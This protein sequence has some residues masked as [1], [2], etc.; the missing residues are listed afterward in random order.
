MNDALVGLL[1][2]LPAV[3]A[4][5]IAF[6]PAKGAALTRSLQF[7]LVLVAALCAYV[8]WQRAGAGMPRFALAWFAFQNLSVEFSLGI[9]GLAR[10]FV[11]LLAATALLVSLAGMRR[12]HDTRPFCVLL[13]ASLATALTIALA[14]DFVL[15]LVAVELLV[16]LAVL[17]QEEERTSFLPLLV[18]VLAVPAAIAV[19]GRPLD[20]G[21][22]GL[23]LSSSVSDHLRL[24]R[25]HAGLLTWMPFV[26]IAVVLLTLRATSPIQDAWLGSLGIAAG[27]F[28]LARF[29]FVALPGLR[30]GSA[31]FW[32]G[33]GLALLAVIAALRASI[34]Q[35]RQP[36]CRAL[37]CALVLITWAG[38]VCLSSTGRSQSWA[39]LL[40]LAATWPLLR[41][42][43][44]DAASAPFVLRLLSFLGFV[45]SPCVAAEAWSL[46]PLLTDQSVVIATMLGT[47]YALC[48]LAGVRV[49]VFNDSDADGPAG[50]RLAQMG[51]GA[52]LLIVVLVGTLFSAALLESSA[53][54]WARIAESEAR[55]G[56]R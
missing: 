39:A 17:L 44:A 24:S 56:V 31:D 38:L 15:M 26:L 42:V 48:V 5:A 40:M 37:R 10:V 12:V 51:L 1:C 41:I 20:F 54:D 47:A 2:L 25:A 13:P 46:W 49:V 8:E 52:V 23:L 27:S 9:D 33:L 11:P 18:V 21:L 34:G 14:Q 53:G 55:A 6:L 45:V 3:A 22:D 19:V 35:R 50:T 28:V 30:A 16:V 32:L 7:A 4:L 29:V 36:R 43:L